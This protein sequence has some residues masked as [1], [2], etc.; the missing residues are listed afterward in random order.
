MKYL[1]HSDCP[2]FTA[3]ALMPDGRV[4]PAFN[5]TRYIAGKYGVLFFYPLDFNYVSTVELRALQSRM[6]E[7]Q[8]MNAAVLAISC[9]SHLAHQVWRNMPPEAGGIGPVHFP[10]VSDIA[11]VAANGFD[12]LVADAM[13][14]A[15]TVIVD[16]EGKVVMQLRCDSA[17]ERNIDRILGA[18]QIL[19]ADAHE[20]T[21]PAEQIILL[22]ENADKL[23]A[24]G[25]SLVAQSVDTDLDHPV[26][27]ALWKRY[28]RGADGKPALS[29][30]FF[31]HQ[32]E[33]VQRDGL[34]L[35]LREGLQGHGTGLLLPDGSLMYEYHSD[36][37]VPRD[38]DEIGR[39]SAAVKRHLETG[40]IVLCDDAE[41]RA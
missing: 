19:N 26:W 23:R 9:D 2:D 35:V 5:L 7:F 22:E 40:E 41:G 21:A 37:H 24:A 10:L 17:I 12:L 34:T 36:R 31:A 25:L 20:E 15:A 8:S 1:I 38:F 39:L 4:E 32:G 6:A 28:P 11:R 30:P 27:N 13:S 16:R 33:W 18:L 14:E 29:F 3:P